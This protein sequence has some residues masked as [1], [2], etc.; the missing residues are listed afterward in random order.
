MTAM[1]R[2]KLAE[3]L[4]LAV[5]V[6]EAAAATTLQ[7]WRRSDLA[8]ETKGDGSP[9]TVADRA[10]EAQVRELLKAAPGFQGLDIVGEEMG[11]E[12]EGSP[13]YWLVDP[14]DGT[15]S[16]SRGLATFGTMLALVDRETERSVVGVICLPAL[17]ETY[18]AAR[19]L[20]A[21]CNGTPIRAS[22]ETELASVI[23]SA[24]DAHQFRG[25][26]LEEGYVRLRDR[27][28][29]LRGYTDCFAH[30]MTARGA[31]A[32]TL[33][34][35]LNPWDAMASQVIVEEAGGSFLLRP[36]TVELA[37]GTAFDALLGSPA[38]VDEIAR[39][40]GF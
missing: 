15:K 17:A 12:G 23:V 36:S 8:V 4:E 3:A 6:T 34:P 35:G 38:L 40:V 18:A 30:A 29:W 11:R 22:A 33:D 28:P 25:S 37:G 21:T 19:G 5:H 27:V 14:I 26:G 32:V 20:G 39:I 13:Y 24:P 16:F 10:A 31:V 1:D 7:H 9:V 2:E